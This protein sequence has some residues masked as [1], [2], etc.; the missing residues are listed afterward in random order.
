MPQ[1]L[2]SELEASTSVSRRHSRTSTFRYTQEPFFT[3]K[4]RVIDLCTTLWPDVP[5]ESIVVERLRGGSYNRVI[6]ITVPS[7]PGER[8][9]DGL[10]TGSEY[11]LRIPRAKNSEI[12]QELATLCFV[13]DRTTIPVPEMIKFDLTCD[14]PVNEVYNI[15][16]KIPGVRLCDVYMEMSQT[17]RL[18]IVRQ[19]AQ[20]L[21]Q[22]HNVRS[23]TPGYLGASKIMKR[24]GNGKPAPDI[25]VVDFKVNTFKSLEGEPLWGG[26]KDDTARPVSVSQLFAD[27]FNAWKEFGRKT[28]RGET[29]DKLM[30]DFRK[31][32]KQMKTVNLIGADFFLFHPDF[33]PQ[34]ILVSKKETGTRGQNQQSPE[35][36]PEWIVSGVL[37]WDGT[38]YVPYS[39]ACTPP[40]WIWSW[41]GDGEE[42]DEAVLCRTP[43]DREARER[44]ELFDSLMGPCYTEYAYSA[45]H[46][47]VRRLFKF[48]IDGLFDDHQYK[49]V[50]IF[51]ADWRE[52]GLEIAKEL[53]WESTDTLD[54]EATEIS[55][56]IRTQTIPEKNRRSFRDRMPRWLA[57][58]WGL[59]FS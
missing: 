57:K 5:S 59:C 4:D 40:T 19:L 54:D 22:M 56:K 53:R 23:S 42:E 39:V 1:T 32:A 36:L 47:L 37:D 17:E 25:R 49:D 41:G 55:E 38:A 2:P 52:K 31:V 43:D 7:I 50:E 11:V 6:G 46:R 16:P 51:F 20:I 58:P 14:N 3:F 21:I 18:S 15:Q 48:A 28:F 45:G 8:S 30:E 34:N 24:D 13:R 29:E 9:E 44:K 35:H 26:M 33:A 12:D 10:V 27:Q